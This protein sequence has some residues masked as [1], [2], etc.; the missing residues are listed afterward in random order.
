MKRFLLILVAGLML[1][2][3]EVLAQRQ[4]RTYNVDY[5][6]FRGQCTYSY[7]T[8]DGRE[9]FDGS[10]KMD[11]DKSGSEYVRSWGSPSYRRTWDCEYHIKANN[12]DGKLHGAVSRTE[13][14]KFEKTG[15]ETYTVSKVFTGNFSMGMPHGRFSYVHKT[16]Q[17]KKT[18]VVTNVNVGY[19][20]GIFTGPYSINYEYTDCTSS[21]KGRGRYEVNGSFTNDGK[22]NGDWHVRFHSEVYNFKFKNGVL[23]DGDR[24]SKDPKV[25]A[26]AMKYANKQITKEELRAMGYVVYREKILPHLK[27]LYVVTEA[28]FEYGLMADLKRGYT[29]FSSAKHAGFGAKYEYAEGATASS[30]EVVMLA[31]YFT[32]QCFET[33]L[34]DRA[35][36]LR[37]TYNYVSHNDELTKFNGTDVGF[38]IIKSYGSQ[39]E[40]PAKYQCVPAGGWLLP[41]GVCSDGCYGYEWGVFF[42]PEQEK[43]LAAQ[44]EEHNLQVDENRAQDIES[45]LSKSGCRIENKYMNVISFKRT[46]YD[47]ENGWYGVVD[48]RPKD[49]KEEIYSTYEVNI[50]FSDYSANEAKSATRIPN[51]YDTIVKLQASLKKQLT[52]TSEYVAKVSASPEATKYADV[53]N[54]L[55]QFNIDFEKSKALAIDHKD[56]NGTIRLYKGHI[57]M[58]KRFRRFM[59]LYIESCKLNEQIA[60]AQITS[61][62]NAT[63]PALVA[64]DKNVKWKRVEALIATQQELLKQWEA[65]NAVITQVSTLHKQIC[66]S[67]VSVLSEYDAQYTALTTTKLSIAE[68]AAAYT[69]FVD[70]QKGVNS[71]IALY[72]Q[73]V[74]NNTNLATALKLVKC[75]AKPYKAYYSTFDF[76]WKSEG[77]EAKINDMLAKQKSLLEISQR[78]TVK[79]DDKRVKKLKLTDLVEIIKAY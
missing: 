47:R 68:S 76:T 59:P 14:G 35:N 13:T 32:D 71:Y 12:S 79:A 44:D 3:G 24:M 46:K 28:A 18:E 54:T 2:G 50:P 31:S 37:N 72:K 23:V 8:R 41:K 26:F 34:R 70:I 15:A 78:A 62:T 43:R 10:V 51:K 27:D 20:N 65:C 45:K 33:Y 42:S 38:W 73:A 16:V 66:D 52:T 53:K 11:L 60:K 49:S 56:L 29:G 74:E 63:V 9:I 21:D 22:F 30:Y 5:K 7:I 4:T 55:S 69:K 61:Y 1:F 67:G 58:Q 6:D 19:N 36:S 64:W 25:V 17:G 57:A 75:A 40:L 48:C 39:F 77:A